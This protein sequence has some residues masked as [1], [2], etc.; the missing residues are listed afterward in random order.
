MSHGQRLVWVQ[1]SLIVLLGACA[2]VATAGDTWPTWRGPDTMGISL[3]GNPPVEW[4]ETKNIK[5]KVKLTGDASNSSPVIWGDKI[6]FQTAVDT[7]IKDTTPTPTPAP[8]SRPGSSA[9]GARP[10]GM[11]RRGTGGGPGGSGRASRPGGGRG[12]HGF[13]GGTP[14]TQYKFNLVCLD[15][16]TGK[17][18]W[19]E[20]VCQAK[21]HQGHHKDHGFASFSPTTDGELVWAMYGS[22]GMYCYDVN[23]KK[24]WSQ[25]LPQ[26]TTM[27]GEGGAPTVAGKAV[28]VLADQ[29]GESF[30]FAFDK[31]TGDL[32]WKKARDEATSYAT[33]MPV[34]VDGRQQVIVSATS[35][36]RSYDVQTGEVIW[37]C[38]GQT[39]NVIPTPVIGSGMVYC[40]SGFMG[41]ALQAIKLGRTGDLTDSDAVVW[42]VKQATP[43]VPS[44]LLYDG[45]LYVCSVSKEIIS[46][47]DART[48][49]AH[50][51]KQKMDEMKGVYASPTA[52]A[53][54]IY[55]VGREGVSTVLKPSDQYEVLAV[56]TLDDKFDCSPAFVGDEMF[57][58]GKK[59][60][61]CISA[62]Q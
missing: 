40:T 61:Y 21:P 34:T 44:P 17:L 20:T 42:E 56:N 14:T 13:G 43:Y 31:K 22:R 37:Q 41:S 23:G 32:L 58:K 60:L 49:K 10:G 62:S 11:E 46:C 24:I 35:F 27:F 15:R 4:S 39:R 18:L 57:L 55:F 29:R 7:K 30:I 2:S 51:V 9:A 12:F 3:E 28:I 19:E 52:A 38:S 54:R 5:W 26:M 33:P 47:Y 1:I 8:M 53:G 25:E 50:F 16:K 45:R 48:G 59:H 36:I 6:F